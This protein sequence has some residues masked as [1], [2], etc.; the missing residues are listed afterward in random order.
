MKKTLTLYGWHLSYFTG[1]VLCYLRYKGIPFTDQPVNAYTLM[2]RIKKETGAMVMPVITT[3]DGEW[4][5]DSTVIIER[6]EAQFAHRQVT[7]T[8]PVQ[9]FSA[10]LMEAWGDEWWVPIAMHTR[11]SYSENYA[12]F[13]HDAGRALLPYFPAFLQ[14][15]VVARVA[16][17]LRGMLHSVGVRPEQFALLNQWTSDMLDL[18]DAHFSQH[19][20][21]FGGHP[22]IG[23]FGL[24]GTMYG[25]LGRDP[26]PARELI[27]K[28]P[29]LQAWLERMRH[30]DQHN[31]PALLDGDQIAPT[32]APVFK[33]IFAEFLPMLEGINQQ[34]KTALLTLPAGKAL[35]RVL[36]DV[37]CPMGQGTFHRGAL[38]YTLW[39]AQR[40]LDIYHAMPAH[41]QAAV[42]EWL[43]E[44]GG[45][46][47]LTLDIPRLRR[48]G[49]R[50]VPEEQAV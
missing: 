39:M 19:D 33:A 29:A 23:D 12:L 18:L 34:A 2:W 28:R 32:L 44:V 21:L 43:S 45:T 36:A 22:T 40:T 16:N 38:P 35:P 30:P 20:F 6:L 41:A 37:A 9:Q 8:T 48:S 17:K 7:P 31:T 15:R 26:W 3:P 46:A 5:Q 50:V 11:W 25:H 10:S 1:K 27:A 42:R 4:I 47:F 13:E 24:V 49:L 14:R